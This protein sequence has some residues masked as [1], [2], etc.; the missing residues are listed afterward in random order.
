MSNHWFAILTLT[1]SCSLPLEFTKQSQEK[2]ARVGTATVSGRV[3]I[4]GEPA[5]GVTVF[6]SE[7]RIT[8][9]NP[10]GKTDE[11]GNYRITGVP[12]GRYVPNSPA[13]FNP[14]NNSLG[15]SLVRIERDGV[16]QPG[17]TIE[18]GAGEHVSNLRLVTATPNLSL[19]GEIK[20]VGGTLPPDVVLSIYAVREGGTAGND[21]SFQVDARNQF[22][23]KYLLPGEYE[24][25][26]KFSGSQQNPDPQLSRRISEVRH[27]VV[28]SRNNQQPV[29]LT[30]D[31]NQ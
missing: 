17:D 11:R 20:V 12:A 31:L 18:I 23:I 22:E 9:F 8:T 13:P 30:L 15:S 16:P 5:E 24:L 1:L 6:L 2:D 26:M 10:S 3:T 27:K 19:R 7:S 25:R 21:Y 29:I 4:K 28:V 14:F